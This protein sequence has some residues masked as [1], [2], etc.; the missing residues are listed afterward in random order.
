MPNYPVDTQNAATNNYG[1]DREIDELW[2]GLSHWYLSQSTGDGYPGRRNS[3]ARP[4]GDEAASYMRDHDFFQ[5]YNGWE[6]TNALDA[7]D[8]LYNTSDQQPVNQMEITGSLQ[9]YS[10]LFDTDH[11]DPRMPESQQN[12]L[13]QPF[14]TG[15]G[16]EQDQAISKMFS[17]LKAMGG[18]NQTM[19]TQG[20]GTIG[21]SFGKSGAL[22]ARR[23]YGI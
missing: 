14:R 15:M 3:R 22:A 18:D 12:L 9:D 10:G 7:N 23:L 6:P 8:K 13:N 4:A 21:D 2:P 11:I 5:D 19:N 20:E 1:T 17:D 16:V